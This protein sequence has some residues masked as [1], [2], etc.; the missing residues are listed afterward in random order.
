MDQIAARKL[1]DDA[2]DLA[3]K[4]GASYADVRM[5]LNDVSEDILVKNDVVES[6]GHGSD[7]GIGVR[8]LKNGAW[9]FSSFSDLSMKRTVCHKRLLAA[10]CEAIELATVSAKLRS[11]PI[12]LAPLGNVSLTY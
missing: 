7:S 10:V 8:V 3:E 2:L 5:Y 6:V 12:E 9:G 11:F 1:A 4:L